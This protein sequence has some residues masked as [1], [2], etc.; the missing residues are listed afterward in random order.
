MTRNP[1][2]HPCLGQG[3]ANFGFSIP[4][5]IVESILVGFG[6]GAGNQSGRS[7]RQFPTSDH[8]G[9]QLQVIQHAYYLLHPT[10]RRVSKVTPTKLP[11]PV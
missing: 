11:W 4:A 3:E 7:I 1:T 9:P 2:S 5:K 6:E 10:A 8:V